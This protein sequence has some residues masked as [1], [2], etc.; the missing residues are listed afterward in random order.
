MRFSLG[1]T[2][3]ELGLCVRP[4]SGLAICVPKLSQPKLG[5]ILVFIFFL[6]EMLPSPKKCQS[7]G[8]FEKQAG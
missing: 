6:F 4:G 2:Y 8:V 3:L 5:Q 1:F 7:Q